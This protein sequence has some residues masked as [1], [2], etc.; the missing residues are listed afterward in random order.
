MPIDNLIEVGLTQFIDFTVKSSPARVTLVRKIKYQEDYHPAFDYWKQLREEISNIHQNNLPLERLN[1][2]VGRVDSKKQ[3]NYA[4]AILRYQKYFKG[5]HVE[6]FDPGKSFW[7]F[8]E[9]Y[10]R[11][12]PDLGLVVNG[13]PYLIKLYFKGKNEKV[14]KRTTRISLALMCDSKNSLGLNK[15]KPA[16]LNIQKATLY[17]FTDNLSKDMKLA[18]DADADNFIYLWTNL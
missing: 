13:E 6:W 2:L 14:D 18:L 7:I 9:L 5:K 4:E 12:N 3:K 8:K 17:P 11:A 10:V 15:L 1:N 16:V